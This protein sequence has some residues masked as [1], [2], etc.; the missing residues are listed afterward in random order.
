MHNIFLCEVFN[1]SRR[2]FHRLIGY[3]QVYYLWCTGNVF[4]TKHHIA[5]T[6]ICTGNIHNTICLITYT[7][8]ENNF[9]YN[10]IMLPVIVLFHSPFDDQFPGPWG[11]L[12]PRPVGWLRPRPVGVTEIQPRGGG[13]PPP[14][15]P[16]PPLPSLRTSNMGILHNFVHAMCEPIIIACI[17]QFLTV[18]LPSHLNS[19]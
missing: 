7:V 4:F 10:I 8:L 19:I 13:R 6:R 12:R 9:M 5:C 14:P 18:P 2:S 15:P 1:Q 16:P 3:L 11:W 17:H